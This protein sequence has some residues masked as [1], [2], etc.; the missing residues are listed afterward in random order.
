MRQSTKL[1]LLCL[2]MAGV[3]VFL[4]HGAGTGINLLLFELAIATAWW[5]MRS[6][7]ITPLARLTLVG[8]FFTAVMVTVHGSTSALVLNLISVGLTVG[9]LLA[10]ELNAMHR[11]AV[12]AIAHLAAVPVAFLRT[13]PFPQRQAPRFGTTPRGALSA[14][15]VPLILL[16]F[17]GMYRSSN[18]HFDRFMAKVFA[19]VEN[20]DLTLAG[21]FLVGLLISGFLLL[22]SRNE[23][24][25]R[26]ASHGQDQ[27]PP[28]GDGSQVRSELLSATMLLTGLN[29][30]LL[31][32]NV[33]DIKYVWTGFQF[34]GQYLKQFVHEGTYMLLLSILLGAAIVLYHFRGDLNFHR[35]NRV[36]KW[37]SY[38]WLAQ[39][40]ML[41]LSVGMRNYWYIHYYALA[42]KR[43]GVAF[44]L[45]ALC[46]GLVLVMI[47]VRRGRTAHYL[48]R[49]NTVAVYCVA[50]MM[51][52]F[53]WDGIIARYN[54]AQAGR[55]F[56]HLDF[57]AT[58]SDKALP[59]LVWS[60]VE[61]ERIAAFN[62]TLIGGAERYSR[63]LYMTP[64]AYRERIQQRV[65]DFLKEYP[66]RSWKEWNR[67]D[68]KVYEAL[69]GYCTD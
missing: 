41:A 69:K 66:Q 31:I 4:F 33:L 9:I 56:V 30:L 48:L 43:I 20:V 47:K 62:A 5:G 59:G 25:L 65:R 54:M 28:T 12:V 3:Y 63:N 24:L 52:L 23:G 46:I 6:G 35:R 68:A 10:P 42:Y 61:L 13:L 1:F 45:L 26:W 27:L 7:P 37:L 18:S 11:S 49:T 55:A 36:V 14:M 34:D 29:V 51:A 53:N 16:L 39:N 8:A 19:L 57:L 40:M 22:T 67:A 64:E 58:L 21:S 32:A 2:V 44:F 38:A 17:I 60:P 15:L 50:V